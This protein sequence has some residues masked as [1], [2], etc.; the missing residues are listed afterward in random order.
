MSS[1]NDLANREVGEES[2][3]LQAMQQHFARLEVRMNDMGDRI[4]QN[5]EVL[6]RVLTQ[7]QRQERRV[8][9][10]LNHEGLADELGDEEGD[11]I[12][13]VGRMAPRRIRQGRG[14]QRDLI[15]REEVD[16]NLGN[17]KMKIPSFQG[18][19]DPE[20]YLE[21]EK[22]VEM[23][24]DCHHYS[25]ENKVKLEMVEFTDYAIVWWDQLVTNQR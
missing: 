20:A 12:E 4:E 22:K 1:S 3:I 18:R 9:V 16:R 6:R 8:S 23:V 21:W 19:N 10:T 25:E 17:I 13:E 5:E 11:P 2:F 7:T 24:F 15:R 14:I